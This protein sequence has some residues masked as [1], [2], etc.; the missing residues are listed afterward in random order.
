MELISIAGLLLH[1]G[2]E[3]PDTL[4]IALT[5]VVAF[6]LGV[7]VGRCGRS[8]SLPVGPSVGGSDGE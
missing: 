6:A 8:V 4:W 2:T 5:G 1:S 3:H 7:A